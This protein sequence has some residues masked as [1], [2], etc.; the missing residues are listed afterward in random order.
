[1]S[2]ARDDDEPSV[3]YS[4]TDTG[5][6]EADVSAMERFAAALVADVQKNYAP[7]MQQVTDAMLTEV[8]PP[9]AAFYELH[10]FL[11]AHRDAQDVTQQNVY[12]YANG[13][14]MFAAAATKISDMYR[15]SD[16]YSH[17]TVRDVDSAFGFGTPTASTAGTT[18]SSSTNE[19]ML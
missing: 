13:T 19:E 1:M 8:T 14:G 5:Q 9:S 7:P 17:A 10:S 16:A 15:G 2:V 6:I 11:S 12:N 18:S 3:K 4:F